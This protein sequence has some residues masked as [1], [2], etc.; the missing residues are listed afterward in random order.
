L[1]KRLN[2]LLRSDY[3][4]I[5]VISVLF[6]NIDSLLF[7]KDMRELVLALTLF[8]LTVEQSGATFI[9]HFRWTFIEQALQVNPGLDIPHI[10][11]VHKSQAVGIVNI[12]L[13]N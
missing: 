7:E 4:Y 8:S 6:D 10:Y 12:E 2:L 3:E 13:F 11:C 5:P 9:S 1:A